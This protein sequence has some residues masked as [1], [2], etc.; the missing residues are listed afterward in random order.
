MADRNVGSTQRGIGGQAG[1]RILP[2][3]DMGEYEIA[4]GFPDVRG[5]DVT[6]RG[7]KRVGKVH[8][9]LV[10]TAAMRVRYVD[11]ELDRGV[12]GAG[13]GGDRHVLIPAGSVT[14]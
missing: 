12:A 4:E 9:L 3:T 10:D 5:W 6:E 8:E 2:L 7:G 14:L 1:G 11:V 13:A